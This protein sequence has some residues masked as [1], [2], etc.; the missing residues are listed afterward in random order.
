ML[1]LNDTPFARIA[2]GEPDEVEYLPQIAIKDDTIIG[3]GIL[4][5]GLHR[6]VVARQ[7]LLERSPEC[8]LYE[9]YPGSGRFEMDSAALVEGIVLFDIK[10]PTGAPCVLINKEMYFETLHG[11][12]LFAL[13]LEMPSEVRQ[14]PRLVLWTQEQLR[15]AFQALQGVLDRNRSLGYKSM[16]P[17]EFQIVYSSVMRI[18]FK[19]ALYDKPGKRP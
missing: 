5:K 13:L 17:E 19:N 14:K 1:P 3:T 15:N 6:N 10:Y 16:G 12:K 7:H 18:E 11:L 2:F 8:V 4:I 9:V